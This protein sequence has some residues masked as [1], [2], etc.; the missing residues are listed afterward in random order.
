LEGVEELMAPTVNRDF[1]SS[2]KSFNPG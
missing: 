1:T 2:G